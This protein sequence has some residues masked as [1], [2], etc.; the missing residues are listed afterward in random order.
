MWGQG[1]ARTLVDYK[2]M[3]SI[4]YI[5]VDLH[6][7]EKELRLLSEGVHNRKTSMPFPSDDLAQLITLTFSWYRTRLP[8]D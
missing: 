2:E 3:L 8:V 4:K 7:D 1:S 6:M 5:W